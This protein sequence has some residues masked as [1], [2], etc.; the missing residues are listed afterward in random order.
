MADGLGVKGANPA[1]PAPVNWIPALVRD[2]QKHRGACIVIA[3]EQQPPAVHALAHAMNDALG[4]V[5]KT[6]DYIAPV[7]ANPVNAVESLKELIADIQAG[8]VDTLFILGVNPVYDAPVDVRFAEHLLKVK[9]RIHLSLYEDETAELCH[10]HVPEAHF[11]ESW[12]DARAYDGTVSII[13]PLISPL[14]DGKSAHEILAVLGGQAGTTGHDIV[15][16]YW[17]RQKPGANFEQFWQTSLNNGVIADSAFAPK[18]V[19][20]NPAHRHHGDKSE[21]RR[22]RNRL[23][24]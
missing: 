8:Q 15:R 1:A 21:C 3:G 12:G 19:K 5:G 9:L 10:W 2:L 18:P 6:V 11:L 4:N 20:L 14:Y 16:N 23:A 17:Q 13:Q 7:E 24:P 22:N